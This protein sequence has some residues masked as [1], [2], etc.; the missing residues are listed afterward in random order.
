MRLRVLADS[1]EF[2]KLE[3]LLVS[4]RA[5]ADVAVVRRD[6]GW[7]AFVVAADHSSPTA[8]VR[9]LGERLS[10]EFAEPCC[11]VPI[12]RLPLTA[13][14]HVDHDAL[15]ELPALDSATGDAYAAT[16]RG[17]EG[18]G[19]TV[20]LLVDSPPVSTPRLHLAGAS[21]LRGRAF[22]RP[23]YGFCRR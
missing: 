19:D 11:V 6:A 7:T 5:V 22:S 2:L 12:T 17:Q 20:T 9:R 23:R 21:A 8:L 15:A 14:G 1:S 3:R 18:I 4:D 13:E 10:A 16:L